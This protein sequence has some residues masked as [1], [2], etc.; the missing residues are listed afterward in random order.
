MASRSR[1]GASTSSAPALASASVA[2]ENPAV[3]ASSSSPRS[4]RRTSPRRG[5]PSVE[6]WLTVSAMT[7]RPAA[8]ASTSRARKPAVSIATVYGWHP[9]PGNR[10]SVGLNPIAASAAAGFRTE[11]P[12]SARVRARRAGRGRDGAAARQ[13]SGRE[14]RVAWGWRRLHAPRRAPSAPSRSRSS[15]AR[16]GSPRLRIVPVRRRQRRR[17]RADPRKRRSRPENGR[18]S[19]PND[20]LM[21][22][23]IPCSGPSSS[24][25][26]S[27]RSACAAR[28][29][30]LRRRR[31]GRR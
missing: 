26:S 8:I 24:P 10:L 14:I 21:P 1:A 7:S 9:P 25:A 18:P 28:P 22:I 4:S 5:G 30:R 23:G 6:A 17:A 27:S 31:S 3:T 11:P 12:P 13:A 2:S 20:S 16:P 29:E 15:C 19:T